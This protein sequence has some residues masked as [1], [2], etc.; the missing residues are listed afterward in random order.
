MVLIVTQKNEDTLE[1]FK[2]ELASGTKILECT[3]KDNEV[4]LS[5]VKYNGLYS[6]GIYRTLIGCSN[7]ND[8]KL[9][10]PEELIYTYAKEIILML[11]GLNIV[12]KWDSKFWDNSDSIYTPKINAMVKHI[13]SMIVY[14]VVAA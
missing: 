9:I 1:L 14:K 10:I 11:T 8:I 7:I 5:S 4:K 13:E 3:L 6:V 12:E 2:L